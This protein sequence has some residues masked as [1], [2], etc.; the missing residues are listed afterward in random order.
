M[1]NKSGSRVFRVLSRIFKLRAWS[2]WD[3]MK[4]FTR[5]L[6]DGIIKFFV[7]QKNKVVESFE[8]A[9]KRLDLS[10][11]VLLERQKGLLR[12]SIFMVVIALL[13]FVYSVY[14]FVTGGY[15]GGIVGIVVMLI[16]LT[17][18]FRYHFWYFQIRERKLG[19]TIQE[20]FKQGLMG[21]K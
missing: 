7:P 18:A 5:Y 19:C 13:L 6:V 21:E 9:K 2:D 14:L 11:K 17:L 15:R 4:S 3:R 16:A 12:L 8:A 1:K 10:D 20:W